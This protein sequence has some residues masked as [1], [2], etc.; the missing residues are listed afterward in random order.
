M[1]KMRR[2]IIWLIRLGFCLALVAFVLVFTVGS[3]TTAY[4]FTEPDKLP[5]VRVGIVFGAQV[6]GKE[7]SPI[8]A[9]RVDGAVELYQKGKIKKILMTGDNGSQ[10]YDEVTAMKLYALKKGIPEG[11]I[12]LDYAGF[13]TYESCYRAKEIFGVSDAILITQDFH[14]PRAVFLCRNMGL[15]VVGYALPDWSKYPNL[16]N[17][18]SVREFFATL[19]AIWEVK[20]THPLPTFLGKFEGIN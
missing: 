10:Y 19:K 5:E 15:P 2:G 16:K 3:K 17:S 11:D 4:R 12:T 13:T 7:L 6:I 18:L 8:L 1:K 20:V 9:D 14:L